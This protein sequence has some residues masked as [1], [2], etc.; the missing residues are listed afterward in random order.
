VVGEVVIDTTVFKGE[1][2]WRPREL[3]QSAPIIRH[4]ASRPKKPTE[5][6]HDTHSTALATAD[7]GHDLQL[8]AISKHPLTEQTSRHHGSIDLHRQRPASESQPLKQVRH[9]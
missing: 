7:E 3:P 9:G 5:R 2:G 1:I 8:V 6:C 4:P